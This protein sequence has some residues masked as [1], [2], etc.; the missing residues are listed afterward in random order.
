MRFESAGLTE[1]AQAMPEKYKVPGNAVKAYRAFYLGE[2]MRFARWTRR[3]LPRWIADHEKSSGRRNLY[4]GNRA[5][6]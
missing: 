5:D 2:K 1:F 6:S 3:R 4:T